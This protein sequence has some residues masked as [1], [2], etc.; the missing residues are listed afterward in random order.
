MTTSTDNTDQTDERIETHIDEDKGLRI[1]S[2]L[3][4]ID[5]KLVIR[6]PRATID[7]PKSIELGEYYGMVD[8]SH[9]GPKESIDRPQNPSLA[10]NTVTI[11][12]YGEEKI[13]L[14]IEE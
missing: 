12:P 1:P 7:H 11:K 2:E 8:D 3:Q 5:E 4:S 9:F 6:T 13:E 14:V 10:P